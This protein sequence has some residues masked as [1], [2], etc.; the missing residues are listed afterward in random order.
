M[1]VSVIMPVYNGEAYLKVAVDS[2]LSQSMTDFELIIIDDCSTDLTASIINSYTDERIIYKRNE[3]NMGVAKSLNKGL[4]L[5]KGEYIARMDA[6]DISL[7]NRFQVQVDFMDNNQDVGVCGTD[8]MIFGDGVQNEVHHFSTHHDDLCIDLIFNTA[9]AH[10]TIMIRKSILIDNEISYDPS[11]ETAEDYKLYIDLSKVSKISCLPQ[12]LLRY[13]VHKSQVTK[14][15]SC[16]QKQTVLSIRKQILYDISP[17]YD[18]NTLDIFNRICDGNRVFQQG[19]YHII[20]KVFKTTIKSNRYKRRKIMKVLSQIN[21]S[22][23]IVNRNKHIYVSYFDLFYSLKNRLLSIIPRM[24][25][26]I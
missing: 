1:K 21:C 23:F 22:I 26:C 16:K 15:F 6:D 7:P 2:I 11:Y 20:V 14:L 18:S 4:L 5:A 17:E 8:I 9:L 13:R 19:E 10:P 25:F 3:H 12:I 24:S